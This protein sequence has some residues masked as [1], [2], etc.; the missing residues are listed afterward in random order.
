MN[1]KSSDDKVIL[2]NATLSGDRL[3]AG[4]FYADPTQLTETTVYDDTKQTSFRITLPD[5]VRTLH[6]PMSGVN[7]PVTLCKPVVLAV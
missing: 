4:I 2:I 1:L 7:V 3:L 6:T 5:Q